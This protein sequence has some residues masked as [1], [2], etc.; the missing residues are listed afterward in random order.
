MLTNI[1]VLDTT[2]IAIGPVAIIELP[3]RL[4]SG[5]HGS[6]VEHSDL[7]EGDLCDSHGISDEIKAEFTKGRYVDV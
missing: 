7:P 5:I 3:F 6:W 1:V 4:R 2:S